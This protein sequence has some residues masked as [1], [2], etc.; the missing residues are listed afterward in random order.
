MRVSVSG[1]IVDVIRRKA[2]DF[3][4]RCWS[5]VLAC[6]LWF[7]SIGRRSFMSPSMRGVLVSSAVSKQAFLYK[8]AIWLRRLSCLSLRASL[9]SL[10]FCTV[11]LPGS[12][13]LLTR[14]S[15]GAIGER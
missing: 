5:A 3:H 6:A 1:V 7:P 12:S 2:W 15:L 10:R 4:L 11:A 14:M 13:E 9:V 8:F